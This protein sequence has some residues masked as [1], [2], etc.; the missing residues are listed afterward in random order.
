MN[1]YFFLNTLITLLLSAGLFSKN[2]KTVFFLLSILLISFNILVFSHSSAQDHVVTMNSFE[3]DDFF[4]EPLFT[5]I[6]KFLYLFL[7]SEFVLAATFLFVSVAAFAL[8]EKNLKNV[9]LLFSFC[10]SKQG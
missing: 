5:I 1:L 8:I 9:F 4:F 2:F 6:T 10:S 7:P 3:Q